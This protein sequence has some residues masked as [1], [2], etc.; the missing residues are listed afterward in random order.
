M[1]EDLV[2][3]SGGEHFRWKAHTYPYATFAFRQQ[4]PI[5]PP[6]IVIQPTKGISSRKKKAFSIKNLSSCCE[7]KKIFFCNGN[8]R[9]R[10]IAYIGSTDRAL[11]HYRRDM[12]KDMYRVVYRRRGRDAWLRDKV[13]NFRLVYLLSV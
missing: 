11:I 6:S 10:K 13:S 5:L 3:F 8:Y 7:N 2:V 9:E 12:M 1:T 4:Y